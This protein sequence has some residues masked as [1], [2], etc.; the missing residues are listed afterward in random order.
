V[1]AAL[2]CQLGDDLYGRRILEEFGRAGTDLRLSEVRAGAPTPL[3]VILVNEA[4]GSRTV[5]NRL[6]PAEPLRFGSQ[7][8]RIL[9]ELAPEV[10]LFDGHQPE[11]SLQAICSPGPARSWTRA[12]AGGAPSCWP[13]AWS[14]WC[15]R[16]ASPGP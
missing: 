4:N 9:A 6:P 14:S 13:R 1:P 11:A 16:S 8:L 3:S 12:P 10:L 7:A 15:L 5:V 2:A